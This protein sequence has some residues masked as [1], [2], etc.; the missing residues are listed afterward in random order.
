MDADLQEQDVKLELQV[1]AMIWNTIGDNLR[2]SAL[3]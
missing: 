3:I 1:S 2:N